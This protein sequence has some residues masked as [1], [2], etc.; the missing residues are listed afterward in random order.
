MLGRFDDHLEDQMT[1]LQGERKIQTQGG[2]YVLRLT[3]A[4]LADLEEELQLQSFAEIL[5]VFKNVNQEKPQIKAVW[6]TVSKFLTVCLRRHHPEITEQ[7]IKDIVAEL[8]MHGSAALMNG[9]MS[10][11]NE[12]PGERK[13]SQDPNVASVPVEA[14]ATSWA[15]G[16]TRG[17]RSRNSGASASQRS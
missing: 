12:D 15:R 3:L 6:K 1:L 5:D 11:M 9:L 14:S 13:K 4:E 16:L 17:G 7:Q 8:G 10:D 2:E